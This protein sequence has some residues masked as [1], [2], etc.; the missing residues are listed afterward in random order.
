V[1]IFVESPQATKP[2]SRAEVTALQP[3][4]LTSSSSSSLMSRPRIFSTK[5]NFLVKIKISQELTVE[6][7]LKAGLTPFAKLMMLAT[8]TLKSSKHLQVKTASV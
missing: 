1:T 5:S 6:E 4:E 8:S 2:L 3:Q 7:S